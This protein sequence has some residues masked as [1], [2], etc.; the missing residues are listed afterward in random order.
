MEISADTR[1]LFR[2]EGFFS[3]KRSSR[4]PRRWRQMTESSYTA[5]AGRVFKTEVSDKDSVMVLRF[6]GFRGF[7]YGGATTDTR[8]NFFDFF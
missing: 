6:S 5:S 4:G 8:G 2:V 1:G 3:G 7:G